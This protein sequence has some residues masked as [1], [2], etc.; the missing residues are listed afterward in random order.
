MNEVRT[1]QSG[2]IGEE[3]AYSGSWKVQKALENIAVSVNISSEETFSVSQFNNASWF[4]FLH[5]C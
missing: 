4:I 3:G 5:R 2:A 1:C